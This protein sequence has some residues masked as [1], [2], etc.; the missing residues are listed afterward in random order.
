MAKRIAVTEKTLQACRKFGWLAGVVER[1][2]HAR[3]PGGVQLP[4][5]T[6]KDLFGFADVVAISDYQG[7]M[8]IQC[9]GGRNGK[10]RIAKLLEE[11]HAEVFRV[12]AAGNDV[13]VWDW[14]R[15]KHTASTGRQMTRYDAKRWDILIVDG[16]LEAKELL[17][18]RERLDFLRSK[19]T[20]PVG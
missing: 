1:R 20:E 16:Q 12:L 6:T 17:T 19:E 5:A 8:F 7:T 15:Y 13:Q 11:R 2:I 3:G 9:T 14:R 18:Y 10:A 4:N